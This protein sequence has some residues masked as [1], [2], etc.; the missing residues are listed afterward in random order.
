MAEQEQQGQQS[1]EPPE[2]EQ[3]VCSRCGTVAEGT[4]PTWTCSVENGVRHY[5]CDACARANLRAIE[6]RLDSDW[7]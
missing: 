1:P 7:W 3:L 2:P 4:P 5:F 6:G